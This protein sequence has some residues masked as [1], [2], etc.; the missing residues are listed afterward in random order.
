MDGRTKLDLHLD[1]P[2]SI[3]EMLSSAFAL[4]R[5]VPILFLA[6]AAIVVIPYELIVLAI[7]GVGP[8]A[9]GTLRFLPRNCLLIADSVLITPLISALHVQAI[10]QLGDG[11]KPTFSG[12]F[13]LSIPRLPVVFVAAGISGVA[14]GTGTLAFFIPGFL[15]LL[16]WPVVAQAAALESGGPLGALRRSFELTR[17]HRWHGFGVFF[18]AGAIAA[19]PWIAAFKIVGHTST[20]PGSFVVGTAIQIAL[21]S[22]EALATGLLYFDLVARQRVEPLGMPT[23]P[24]VGPEQT[25]GASMVRPTGFP[26]DPTSWSDED[27]PA[28]WYIDL[29]EPARMRYWTTDGAGARSWVGRPTKTPRQTLAEWERLRDRVAD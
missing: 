7:T 18:W 14:I 5:R 28:G 2:R 19:V 4:Y 29:G 3:G 25:G 16:I 10:R 26:A 22:F 1:R 21:R 17:G 9:V 23:A 27:R 24:L 8:L 15:L 12:V 13:R 20:T 11:D 6:F